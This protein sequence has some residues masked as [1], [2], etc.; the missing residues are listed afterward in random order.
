MVKVLALADSY[1][2]D[3]AFGDY[4]TFLQKAG[5]PVPGG[6]SPLEPQLMVELVWHTHMQ[7]DDP[8]RYWRGCVALAR[9][10]VDHNDDI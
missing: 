10:F 8:L 2:P 4:R 7:T 1:D 9:R 3:V 5:A 6:A